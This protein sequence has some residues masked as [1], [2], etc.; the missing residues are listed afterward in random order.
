MKPRLVDLRYL[1]APWFRKDEL[2]I[3]ERLVA[4]AGDGD[5]E[6]GVS[7]KGKRQLDFP[8]IRH[9]EGLGERGPIHLIFH[10]ELEIKRIGFLGLLVRSQ[11]EHDLLAVVGHD[12]VVVEP[13]DAVALEVNRALSAHRGVVLKAPDAGEEN[14]CPTGPEF[15]IS[16]PQILVIRDFQAHELSAGGVDAG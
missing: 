1:R 6:G 12:L 2:V 14:R 11:L 10:V 7:P 8:G 9:A 3:L 4:C 13:C 15:G 16:L 5:V